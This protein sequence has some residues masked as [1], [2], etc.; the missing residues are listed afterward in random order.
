MAKQAYR[1]KP[2]YVETRSKRINLLLRPSLYKTAAG[3]AER[4]E[5]SFNHLMELALIQYL[6]RQ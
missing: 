4:K 5:I 3:L 2:E 6:N 1:T